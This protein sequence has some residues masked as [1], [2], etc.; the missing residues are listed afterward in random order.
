MVVT[1]IILLVVQLIFLAVYQRHFNGKCTGLILGYTTIE[2]GS[3]L[4][5]ISTVNLNLNLI[6][7]L[8]QFAPNQS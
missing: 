6:N 7:Y 2:H 4:T 8:F 3:K 1:C 5:I